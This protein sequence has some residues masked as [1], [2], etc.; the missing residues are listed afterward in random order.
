MPGQ[1]KFALS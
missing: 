1:M